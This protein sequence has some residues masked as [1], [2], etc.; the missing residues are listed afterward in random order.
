MNTLVK[1]RQ[2]F[3]MGKKCNPSF[4]FTKNWKGPFSTEKDR[5]LAQRPVEFLTTTPIS[6]FR[7]LIYILCLFLLIILPQYIIQKLGIPQSWVI[8][9]LTTLWA[10]LAKGKLIILSLFIFF[11]Q[12]I[13]SDIAYKL[14]TQDTI[15]M[16]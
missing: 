9:T 13:D 12:K 3:R 16:K 6:T 7:V 11:F 8:L 1:T 14:S 4:G 5:K 15:C 10:N 2:I